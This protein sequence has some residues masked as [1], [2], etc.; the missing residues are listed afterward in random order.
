MKKII[1]LL[2]VS[3]ML[4][5][6]SCADTANDKNQEAKDIEL[7]LSNET[8]KSEPHLKIKTSAFNH[9]FM[10]YGSFIPMLK[11]PSG[12]SLK[13]R[14][15][16]FQ[17][18]SDR[19]VMLESPKGHSIA[20]DTE[21]TILLAEF[22]VIQS[23]SEGVV[24]DFAKGM[25]SAFTSR[26][27]NSDGLSLKETT[28]QQF[29]AISLSASFIKSISVDEQVLTV[30]QIAQWRNTQSE[31]VSAEFRYFF[32][33]YAP[34][35]SFKKK[36]FGKHRWVQ[37]FSTPELV[38]AP[39]T[40]TVAYIAK[41]PID[42]PIIFYVSANT[43]E[44]YREAIKDGV[45][46]WNHIFGREILQV[47]DLE[48]NL[49]APH[50]HLNI[51][52]W[53]PWDNEASAY[54]DMVV[55][56]LTG[57][58]LQA[59]VFLRSGWVF[60][61]AKK[62]RS[63]LAELLLSEQSPSDDQNPVKDTPLPSMLNY[64]EPCLQNISSPES[65]GEL[66]DY[67][68]KTATADNIINII[69]SDIV[70]TVVAHEMGHVLGLRHNLAA[71]TASALT[72]DERNALLK[73]YL[74]EGNAPLGRDKRFSASIMDVFSAADDAL[75]GSQLR[76]LIKEDIVNSPLASLYSYDKQAID[77]GYFDQAMK[78]DTP[79]CYDQEIPR[80][81]D[82]QRW[83]ASNEPFLFTA[84]RLNTTA[85]QI[86]VI[87][88]ETII[89][90]LDPE[91]K[92]GPLHV[93]DVQLLNANIKK[94]FDNSLKQ[95]FSWFHRNSRSVQI[96]AHYP[97]FSN[98]TQDEL[99]RR[100]FQS[101]REQLAL[102]GL[103]KTLFSIMPP[104][105]D[106]ALEAEALTNKFNRHFLALSLEAEKKNPLFTIS[107]SDKKEAE[108]VARNFFTVLNDDLIILFSNLVA[109]AQLDDNE[110]QQP[111]E[112]ALG[113]I[114]REI[115]LK[116]KDNKEYPAR[117]L[118]PQFAYSEPARQAA[119]QLL[120]PAMGN[121]PDWAFDTTI[122]I[123]NRLKAIM[124]ANAGS[125]DDKNGV[126]LSSVSRERRRWLIEQNRLLATLSKIAS[127][128]RE[129]MPQPAKSQ[130]ALLHK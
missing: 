47:K 56:H 85:I 97:V 115:V 42:Q 120:N 53:V 92:G 82:C 1:Y 105:R 128:T 108:A 14:I 23:D 116:E 106:P 124:R 110:L 90:A 73:E 91:R 49:S 93:S 20:G 7:F 77:Y 122:E 10:F 52:Q 9:D 29:K 99:N 112:E 67:F 19:V 117:E 39:T 74:L 70:R 25:S 94:S 123:N 44:L 118:P 33:E 59:Q 79:F 38:L 58:S 63:Q 69:T 45:L 15:I 54:A 4:G 16:R 32:R 130:P 51:I 48:P 30:S 61:S 88:A 109:R 57:E 102:K 89:G 103:N 101:V 95:L 121:V 40:E 111:L 34:S 66:L 2:V 75:M 18:M 119:V 81:L 127:L 28:S 78:G 100:R 64:E 60:K 125:V 129:N 72:L 41:W 86:A 22:P 83:D 98:H 8:L 68:S 96:E 12:Y 76:E 80:Y 35:A 3:M 126:N 62:I 27:V 26:N 31:L 87:M 11:S 107:D 71:S 17:L 84:Q 36:S 46:F 113:K 65:M 55:D 43:P 13:G 50:P 24:I 21:S 114:V 6:I 37:Y 5:L 104:F